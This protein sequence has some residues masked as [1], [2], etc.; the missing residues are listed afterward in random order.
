MPELIADGPIIPVQLMNELDSGTVV[1]FCGAGVSAGQGSKL[2]GFKEL[3]DQVYRD[4]HMKPDPV[5][6]MA[7]DL[8]EPNPTRRQP[9]FDKALGLLERPDRL[10]VE[11]LRETVIKCLSQPSVGSL[12][13]HEALI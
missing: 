11:L 10:G 4:N 9:Q 3:V 12:D 6:R 13:V 8:D 2:P 5:E 1:F 7:L